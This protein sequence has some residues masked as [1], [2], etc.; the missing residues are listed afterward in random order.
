[1]TTGIGF[2]NSFIMES[3]TESPKAMCRLI[4]LLRMLTIYGENDRIGLFNR[5]ATSDRQIALI[6]AD[7]SA[8][9]WTD[10]WN[11]CVSIERSAEELQTRPRYVDDIPAMFPVLADDSIRQ[12]VEAIQLPLQVLGGMESQILSIKN[13]IMAG[14]QMA[15]VA[16]NAMELG[17]FNHPTHRTG[18]S[19]AIHQP[20]SPL[21]R[22]ITLL[23][24]HET[25]QARSYPSLFS[26]G[27][28]HSVLGR[29]LPPV[30]SAVE[31]ATPLPISNGILHLE[32]GSSVGSSTDQSDYGSFVDSLC[33]SL[34]DPI[35]FVPSP[36]LPPAGVLQH[37]GWNVYG[38]HMEGRP[39]VFGLLAA[40]LMSIT[41]APHFYTVLQLPVGD[42]PEA[43]LQN[44]RDTV[45][46]MAEAHSRLV[47][48]HRLRADGEILTTLAP[49]HAMIE[50][51]VMRFAQAPA[52][53]SP[54]SA[55]QG[56]AENNN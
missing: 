34:V 27:Y 28:F 20:E 36:A 46:Q 23:Q 16:I 31:G 6:P 7:Q 9:A 22:L 3:S 30:E 15:N 44:A 18:H 33:E 10:I 49:L 25:G 11:L 38:S 24:V 56:H 12:M 50:G 54:E 42:I 39:E 37:P 47:N 43:D 5:Q 14:T 17:M 53:P 55:S 19:V 48:V 45:N 29:P 35:P 8:S 4:T 41:E 2:D 21:L 26:I 32:D 52:A 51:A 13:C 40:T 1:M